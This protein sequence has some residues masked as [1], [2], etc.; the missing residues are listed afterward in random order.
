VPFCARKSAFGTYS[1]GQDV[2]RVCGRDLALVGGVGV[3]GWD[4]VVIAETRRLV[5]RTF[6]AEDLPLYA[7]LNADPEVYATLSG[8]PLSRQDSD[9]TA[10]WAQDLFDAEGIGLLAVERRVDRTFVGM[11][12]LHHQAS[13]PGDVEVGWRLAREYWG[14]GYATEAAAAWLD[15]GFGALGLDRIISITDSDNH[16]SLAVMA[17]LG[18]TFDH[19]ASII[20]E[21]VEHDAVVYAITADRWSSPPASDY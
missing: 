6:V 13:Y 14:H 8:E 21:G 16:R 1:L 9:D 18:M 19:A 17:R 15:R 12:G 10:A 11:C 4:G 5:L 3:T 2:P 7:A 20:D